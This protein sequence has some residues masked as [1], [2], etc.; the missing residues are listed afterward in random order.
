VKIQAI[1]VHCEVTD[2]SQWFH[3]QTPKTW[4]HVSG[5]INLRFQRWLNVWVMQVFQ[6]RETWVVNTKNGDSDTRLHSDT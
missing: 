6:F 3:F 5:L 4:V 1:T 2:A